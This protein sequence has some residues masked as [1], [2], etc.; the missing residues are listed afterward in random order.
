MKWSILLSAH[1]RQSF[2]RIT[3]QRV[4]AALSKRIDALAESP[5][6][7]GKPLGDDLAGYRSVRAVGQRWR[8]IYRL[9]ND[10]IIVVVVALGL[11]Q[12]RDRDD[13]YSRLK[14]MIRLG[15]IGDEPS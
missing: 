10:R 11:R 12:G 2:S 9:E 13:V 8:I 14:R 3:D 1:A 6:Q 7:Q 4:R 5:E 15:L